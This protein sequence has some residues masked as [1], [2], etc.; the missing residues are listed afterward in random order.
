MSRIVVD[1]DRCKACVVCAKFCPK[2]CIDHNGSFN[3][4]GY[5][6]V[7]QKN[8]DCI[9]CGICANMCPEGAITVY[10]D[11]KVVYQ[12]PASMTETNLSYCPGCSHGTVN[13]IIGELID[14]M[15]I[16][17]KAIGVTPI[18]CSIFIYKNFDIDYI[19]GAH[20]RAPAVA[21]GIKRV[22][23]DSVVFTYQGDGDI[24]A[25]GLSEALYSA[26]R[27]ENFT[28][29]FVNNGNYGMTGG[30]AAPTTLVGQVTTT[31]PKGK[32]LD[33]GYPVK[34]CE[35]IATLGSDN[36]F[37]ARTSVDN[38]ANVRKTKAAI[39][40]AF[41]NQINKVGF[42]L[43]EVLGACPTNW[44]K[45]PQASMDYIKE[46]MIPFFPLGEIKKPEEA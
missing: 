30:Q 22:H 33:E 24:G 29:I 37:I 19:E 44:K 13:R 43:V 45:T 14:E 15:G 4:Y 42:S 39:R 41:E 5:D 36:A 3:Q 23:P 2:K 8:D 38:P 11:E 20:G 46:T 35:T 31:T 17:D 21:T 32:T 6:F 34:F 12:R 40:K 25:I 1:K 27:D 7:E 26:I 28:I 16:K 10:K 18:G 9:G